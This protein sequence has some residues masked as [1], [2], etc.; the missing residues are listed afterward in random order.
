MIAN[1]SICL[2]DDAS[3]LT[4][5]GTRK[6]SHSAHV[7]PENTPAQF[8]FYTKF[9]IKPDEQNVKTIADKYLKIACCTLSQNIERGLYNQLVNMLVACGAIIPESITG[10]QSCFNWLSVRNQTNH[11][12]YLGRS[13]LLTPRSEFAVLKKLDILL[14]LRQ[15]NT[16]R[17]QTALGRIQEY[18]SYVSSVPDQYNL[19]LQKDAII[20]T[21]SQLAP[22][23]EGRGCTVNWNGLSL[24]CQVRSQDEHGTLIKLETVIQAT[25]L[26]CLHCCLIPWNNMQ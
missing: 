15:E 3:V 26:N 24:R 17:Q 20:F 7:T 12:R 5:L 16:T 14:N 11:T 6:L 1:E 13:L 23:A 10:V 4:H 18:D 19:A 21:S 8:Y 2:L 25:Q 9:V 22:P